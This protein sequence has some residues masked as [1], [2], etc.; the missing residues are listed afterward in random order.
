MYK[1][2]QSVAVG[3]GGYRFPP[4]LPPLLPP[5]TIIS[6]VGPPTTERPRTE[7]STCMNESGRSRFRN[8]INYNV[9][10]EHRRLREHRKL[11]YVV[12][13]VGKGKRE[14]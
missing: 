2:L 9:T 14:G 11:K 13:R 1:S 12:I 5:V 8:D 4:S 7:T 10:S 3:H 6:A